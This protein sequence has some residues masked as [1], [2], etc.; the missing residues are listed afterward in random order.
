[1]TRLPSGATTCVLST[2]VFASPSSHGYSLA[3][4]LDLFWPYHVGESSV[5][6]VF[7]DVLRRVATHLN[8]VH[9]PRS[10]SEC[11]KAADDFQRLRKSPIWGV[12][13]ALDGISVAIKCPTL[14]DTPSPRSFYNRKGFYSVCVQA[15][16]AA[17]YSFTFFNASN[18]GSTHD[19]TAFSTS[20]LHTL[21]SKAPEAEG[22]PEFAVV[23][24]D[25]AYGNG[26][27]LG[28]VMTP[29]SGTGLSP[30]MDVFNYFWSSLRCIIEQAFGILVSRWGILWS[31]LR[32]SLEKN[33]LIIE[34]CIKMHNYI[35]AHRRA[36]DE[37][38]VSA[39][40]LLA[41]I[42]DADERNNVS[43][44]NQ[45]FMQ[46]LYHTENNLMRDRRTFSGAKRDELAKTLYDLGHRRP[47]RR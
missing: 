1:M 15:A 16:C 35:V 22:L 43:G 13:S 45:V 18:C 24:A 39:E 47:G 20:S 14:A 40:S 8:T 27:C 34:A 21:L 4:T 19:S 44:S 23:A 31:P 37:S 9:F 12:V 17:D 7:S 32:Y 38:S 3:Q 29:K 11:K 2:L 26:S 10:E 25:D 41:N 42:E 33:I 30:E 36:R 5:Y 6:S 28:R 46:D